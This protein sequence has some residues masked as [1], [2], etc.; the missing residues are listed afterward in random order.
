MKEL[1]VVEIENITGG[2]ECYCDYKGKCTYWGGNVTPEQ[3]MQGCS[4]DGL[5]MCKGDKNPCWI[6]L[7]S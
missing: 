3:C 1:N 5:S 7:Q 2:C 4:L 6:E